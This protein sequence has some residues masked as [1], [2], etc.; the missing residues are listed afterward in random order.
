MKPYFDLTTYAN[1][2]ENL[3]KDWPDG[4]LIIGAAPVQTKTH[5]I[6]YRYR[7][8][9]D[10]LYLTGFPEP[11]AVVVLRPGCPK[12]PYTLFVQPKDPAKEQ[13]E[14]TRAGTELTI[15]NFGA[16]EAFNIDELEERLP[17]LISD[18]PNLYYSLNANPV[19]DQLLFR[20][21]DTL[22]PK[23]DKP[24]RVPRAI[25]D[26]GPLLH[27]RRLVKDAE[28]AAFI[29]KAVD[30]AA[31]A[32]IEAMK[33]VRPG[34]M[35]YQV[36]ALL[37]YSFQR[38]GATGPCYDTIVGGGNNA[39][40][41]HYTENSSVLKDGE[42]VL[43]DAG[44]EYKFYNGDITRTFPI[45]QKFT[46]VQKTLYEGVLA[47]QKQAIENARVGSSVHE[48]T[49]WSFRAMTEL[50]VDV[51]L[52]KGK[53][54]DLVEEKEYKRFYM[55]GLGHYMG[56]DVHDVGTYLV[57]TDQPIDLEP[58][59]VLTIEPGIYVGQDAEDVPEEMRGIGIRIEDNILI[60]EGAAEVLSSGIPKEI[61]DIEA[62]RREAF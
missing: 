38:Q 41:L 27:D 8:L 44:P 9:S 57:D 25:F 20:V 43:I 60:T 56:I 12:H 3:T 6:T 16:S 47:V 19:L 21:F 33:T 49:E 55:H 24:N 40:I 29:R 54:D 59:V 30:I 34:Q 45:G 32:H 46:P 14:G 39:T 22:R 48:L 37:D 35:E 42:L 61:D 4:V 26:P 28:E 10:I 51:G 17:E 52:L 50:M 36:A 2:R 13:W 58:G 18:R 23:R 1:R 7:P 62:L 53:V 11:E 15:E 31:T 5:D